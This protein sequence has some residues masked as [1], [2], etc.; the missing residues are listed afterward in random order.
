MALALGPQA[1]EQAAAGLHVDEGLPELATVAGDDDVAAQ[2]R[3]HDLLAVTDAEDRQTGIEEALR[4]ARA[5]LGRDRGRT[6]GQDDAG[7]LD[8]VEG[9]VGGLEGRDLRIDP[10]LSHPAGDELRDLAAEIDDENAVAVLH[11]RR[12]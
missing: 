11:G 2:L 10:S 5:V 8:P 6:T 7:R 12:P 3:G 4:H 9:L 1:V